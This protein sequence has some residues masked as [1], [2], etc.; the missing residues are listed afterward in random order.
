MFYNNTGHFSYEC[1]VL[2]FSVPNWTQEKKTLYYVAV[3]LGNIVNKSEWNW[4][5][6]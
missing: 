4:K 6:I 3:E 2:T 5:L 1:L